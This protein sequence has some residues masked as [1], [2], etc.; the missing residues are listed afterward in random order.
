MR[1]K[2]MLI[3]LLFL[4][5]LLSSI[6]AQAKL[7]VKYE[8]RIVKIKTVSSEGTVDTDE[9]EVYYAPNPRLLKEIKDY[10]GKT[11]TIIFFQMGKRKT[12]SK[13]TPD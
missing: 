2:I 7:A 10:T 12:I 1:K 9:G 8:E 11:A 5:L 4:A 6:N 13:I 3:S